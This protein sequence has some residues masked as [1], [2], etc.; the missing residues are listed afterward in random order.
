MGLKF[1]CHLLT[2]RNVNDLSPE[3]NTSYCLSSKMNVSKYQMGWQ[4]S[5][6]LISGRNVKD[7]SPEKFTSN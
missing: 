2:G 5:C 1:S 6:H 4:L 3:R 7:L